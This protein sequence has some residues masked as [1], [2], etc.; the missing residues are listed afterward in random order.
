MNIK[1]FKQYKWFVLHYTVK[2]IVLYFFWSILY[3]FYYGKSSV[4][5]M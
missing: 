4:I 5:N 2:V 1:L 3:L